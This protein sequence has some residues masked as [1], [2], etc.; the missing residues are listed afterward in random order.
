MLASSL[1]TWFGLAGPESRWLGWMTNASIDRGQIRG[2]YLPTNRQFA[3]R[4]SE[5]PLRI[6][7]PFD[8][9]TFSQATTSL[10]SRLAR[11]P[12]PEITLMTVAHAPTG[13]PRRRST[14]KLVTAPVVANTVVP[15]VLSGLAPQ[16]AETPEQATERVLEELNAYLRSIAARIA[17]TGTIATEAHISDHPSEIIIESA[18]EHDADVIVMAT[19]SRGGLARALFGSTTEKV[20]RSGVAP[21]LIVHPTD[22]P[23]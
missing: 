14:R 20:V 11:L 6:L 10:L 5:G 7:A 17:S 19:H 1:G 15:I 16:A 23:D 4:V 2:R 22:R 13:T 3:A 8:Q 12:D 9:T 21:V 18:R